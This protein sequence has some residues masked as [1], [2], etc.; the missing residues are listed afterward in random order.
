VEVIRVEGCDLVS[1]ADIA[2]RI[3]RSR[4]LVHQYITGKRGPGSFP[5]AMCHLSGES[6]LWIWCDVA[7]WLWRNDMIR[8]EMLLDAQQIAGINTVL[9][10][11]RQQ[12]FA[13]AFIQEA[14]RTITVP[15]S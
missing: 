13:P 8:E 5:P 10:L 7:H 12:R 9:D 11:H 4:Q 6:A 15:D 2:R 1:Q 3:G 14:M